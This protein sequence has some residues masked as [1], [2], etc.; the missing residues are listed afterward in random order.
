MIVKPIFEA[1]KIFSKIDSNIRISWIEI[2]KRFH[3]IRIR[4]SAGGFRTGLKIVG[5]K[6][7]ESR[8]I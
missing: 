7:I 1:T 5:T 6:C 2:V 8:T 4:D 3:K